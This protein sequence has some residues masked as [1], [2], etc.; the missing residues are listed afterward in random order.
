M[1]KRRRRNE[2]DWPN[3]EDLPDG[4]RRYWFRRPGREWGCQILLKEVVFD[5]K[6]QLEETVRL[7]QEIY[8]DTGKLVETHQKYPTDTGHKK[9]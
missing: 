8:D 7:W 3:H 9:V 6:T 4:R 1:S 5:P 2:R